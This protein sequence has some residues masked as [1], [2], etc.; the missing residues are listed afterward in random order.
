MLLVD[1]G[2]LIHVAGWCRMVNSSIFNSDDLNFWRLKS[3]C[4]EL[5]PGETLMTWPILMD[6][7]TLQTFFWHYP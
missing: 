3:V 2:W 5:N 4:A 6:F 1:T 7:R